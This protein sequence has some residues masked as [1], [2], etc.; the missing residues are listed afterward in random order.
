MI[1]RLLLLLFLLEAEKKKRKSRREL[2]AEARGSVL[3]LR[4]SAGKFRNW[5][6]YTHRGTRQLFSLLLLLL[7]KGE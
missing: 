5:N 7:R 2:Y 1:S 3:P 6:Y 4:Y